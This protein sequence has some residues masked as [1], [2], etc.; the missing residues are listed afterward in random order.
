MQFAHPLLPLQ[1]HT[2][3]YGELRAAVY[4]I[5]HAPMAVDKLLIATD[6]NYVRDGMQGAVEVEGNTLVQ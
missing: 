4:L 2:N 6:S 5:Q 1:M 3:N